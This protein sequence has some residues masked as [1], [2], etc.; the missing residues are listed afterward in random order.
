[1]GYMRFHFKTT[2]LEQLFTEEIGARRYPEGVIRSFFEVMAIIEN[3]RDVNDVRALKSLH[4]E[5]LKGDRLGQYSLRLNKQYRLIIDVI[6]DGTEVSILIIAIT[7]Y[8]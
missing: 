6:E 4:L 1:M 3:A 2:D 8:H 7:D 5:K